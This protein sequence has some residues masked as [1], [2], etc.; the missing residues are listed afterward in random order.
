[1]L[2]PRIVQID[3]IQKKN[4]IP[5]LPAHSFATFYSKD[6]ILDRVGERRKGA[7]GRVMPSETNGAEL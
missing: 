1:M 5:H 6:R 2:T 4:L 7:C 3:A